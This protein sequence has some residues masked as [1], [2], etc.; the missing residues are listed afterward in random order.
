M[1]Y[2]FLAHKFPY[3]STV[4]I[5]IKT[6]MVTF[7]FQSK[8]LFSKWRSLH[9]RDV[10]IG[11]RTIKTSR[12]IS[13]KYNDSIKWGI[14]KKG[15][16]LKLLFIAIKLHFHN[17]RNFLFLLGQLT[18]SPHPHPTERKPESHVLNQVIEG[19]WKGGQKLISS[20]NIT[21]GRTRT[22]SYVSDNGT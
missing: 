13:Q 20:S 8:A 19:T 11:N 16:G 3:S 18:L 9:F 4:F 1:T 7:T 15:A 14:L 10:H 6:N 21:Y 17:R 12:W 2:D 22:P 5:L